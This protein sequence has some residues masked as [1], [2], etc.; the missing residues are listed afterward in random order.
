MKNI[1]TTLFS[2]LLAVSFAQN[3]DTLGV[4]PGTFPQFAPN[5]QATL[6][7]YILAGGYIYG[8][9]GDPNNFNAIAQG[10]ELLAPAEVEGVLSFIAVK[11]KGPANQPSTLTFE[12]YNMTAT[13]AFNVTSPNPFETEPAEGPSGNVLGS[14]QIFYEEID[15]TT[16]TYT[17]A[18]F[19]NPIFVQGN[20][21]VAANLASLRSAGDTIAFLSDGIGDANGR[22]YA[23][24]R[25]NNGVTNVW[26]TS[27]SI[28]GGALD[29]NIA[30][31]PVLS[32]TAGITS[33]NGLNLSV[34]PNPASD[35]LRLSLSSKHSEN[36]TM[37]LIDAQGRETGIKTS[38]V[39]SD[40]ESILEMDIRNLTSGHYFLTLEGSSGNR[41]ARKI[42]VQRN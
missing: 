39:S 31:F 2:L 8:T 9:N 21:A 13:G 5:N 22:N 34:Y 29:N 24:H 25:V 19:S 6:L 41:L 36:Y 40:S 26:Y 11:R 38:V 10:Y 33:L 1:F 32:A 3:G 35:F 16:L 37:K 42:L 15:T 7:P 14:S 23:Y 28:F 27:N 12:L 4:S 18:E 17:W 20:F 30:I